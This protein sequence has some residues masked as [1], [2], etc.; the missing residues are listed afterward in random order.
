MTYTKKEFG[1]ELQ[2][3]ILQGY[4][5]TEISKWAFQVYIK[6]SLLIESG[7]DEV[8][9]KLIAMEEGPEFVLSKKELLLLANKFID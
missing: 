9:L 3:Q 5:Q 7:L 6:Q 8:V 4:D 1:L 2:A